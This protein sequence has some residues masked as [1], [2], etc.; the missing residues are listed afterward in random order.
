MIYRLDQFSTHDRVTLY[1]SAPLQSISIQQASLKAFYKLCWLLTRHLTNIKGRVSVSADHT[2]AGPYYLNHTSESEAMY[3]S[4]VIVLN[5]L[6][7][8]SD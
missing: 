4:I 8:T 1:D 2:L 6:K 7:Q 3:V 5:K